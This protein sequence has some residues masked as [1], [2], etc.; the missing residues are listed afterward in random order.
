M[1]KI[2][3]IIDKYDVENGRFG[4]HLSDNAAQIIQMMKEYAEWYAQR[5]LEIAAN[6]ACLNEPKRDYNPSIS[7][8]SITDI[9]LPDHDSI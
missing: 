7:K 2:K 9:E 8:L 4:Q 6:E 5:C 1:N 3:E